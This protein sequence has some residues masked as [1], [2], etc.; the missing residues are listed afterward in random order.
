LIGRASFG[1]PWIF[2]EREADWDERKV[3]ALEHA[4]LLDKLLE[5]KG[6]IRMR[7]HLLDYTKGFEGAREL[8]RELMSITTLSEV[9]KILLD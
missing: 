1:N 8:R 4:R 3:I 2:A 9:E 6:F 7:K 5:G